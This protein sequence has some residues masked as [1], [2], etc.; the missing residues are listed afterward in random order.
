MI[1]AAKS[2]LRFAEGLD[3]SQLASNEEKQSAIL[4]QVIIGEATKRLSSEFRSQYTE[5]PWKDISGMRDILAILAHQ[6]DRININTLWDVIQSDI[7]QLLILLEP[8]L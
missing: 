4:Y 8:L 3:K 6:Y 5:I 1:N 2:V 7:P